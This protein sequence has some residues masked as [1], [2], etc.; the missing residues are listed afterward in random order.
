[1][2]TPLYTL[3]LLAYIVAFTASLVDRE[4]YPTVRKATGPALGVAFL[5][6]LGGLVATVM[7]AGVAA[8]G[9][10]S[11][12]MAFIA[13][14]VAAGFLWTRRNPRAEA[15]GSFVV[16]LA[17]VLLA[18]ALFLPGESSGSIAPGSGLW[19][20]VHATMMLVGLGGFALAFGSK[21]P[22]E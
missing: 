12:S 6:H 11:G 5:A 21:V 4:A 3:A 20:P 22:S 18:L 13:V 14:L 16:P 10:P 7:S 1:M 19:F 2:T 17:I 8:V 9:S 15:V